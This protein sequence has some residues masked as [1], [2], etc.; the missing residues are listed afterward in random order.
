[1]AE[2]KA[3][4]LASQ[5]GYKGHVTR[6][7]HKIDDLMTEEF[8]EYTTM[9]LNNTIGQLSKKMEKIASIDVRLLDA[10]E[11]ES[12]VLEAEELNDEITDKLARARRFMELYSSKPI[13]RDL[14]TA[15]QLTPASSTVPQEL[16]SDNLISQVSESIASAQSGQAQLRKYS[17]DHLKPT[18]RICSDI[19][20]R[21]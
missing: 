19:S 20:D 1:M 5:S 12:T 11:I 3:R 13:S 7:F 9:S 14:P 6:L 16:E 18:A 10:T 17:S 2:E 21:P 15:E 8:D 4:Q